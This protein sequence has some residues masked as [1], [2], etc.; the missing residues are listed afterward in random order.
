MNGVDVE[1][2]SSAIVGAT[3]DSMSLF[4]ESTELGEMKTCGVAVEWG[5][6]AGAG[7][8]DTLDGKER[9]GSNGAEGLS[10]V[11]P[12]L[13]GVR[14]RGLLGARVTPYPESVGAVLA[15]FSDSWKI[16]RVL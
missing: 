3:V 15:I 13:G 8:I 7:V 14:V 1:E 16:K 6:E 4:D 9:G 5:Y 12:T 11:A 10:E 2:G